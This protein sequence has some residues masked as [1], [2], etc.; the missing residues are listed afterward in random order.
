MTSM[1]VSAGAGADYLLDA[2]IASRHP[3]ERLVFTGTGS[4]YFRIWIV[5][6]LLTILTLGIYSAWAKVRRT[7]Y[8]YDCTRLAGSSF[9]YH[10][11]PMAILKGR[12]VAVLFFG[13]YN[14]AAN[15][16][17]VMGM[18][19]LA[20]LAL[21]GPW[22]VWKSLQ[23]KLYNSSYRAIRFGFRGTARKV[24]LVYLLFP[25]LTFLT[26]YVLA[27]LTHQQMK[28]FQH[29]ESRYGNT[30]FS[31]HGTAG[32]FYKAYLIGFLV[33]LAGI[34]VIG[35]TFGG[36][37]AAMASAG[38]LKQTALGTFAL[39][40]LVLYLWLFSLFPLFLTMIQNLIWNNTRLGGH[41]FKSEMRARRMTFIVFTNII[42]IVLTLGL[43][44]PFAKIRSMKYRIESMTLIPVSNLDD[45]VAAEQAEASATGEGAA[46]MLD[47]DLSL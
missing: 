23:F 44:I 17:P 12:V 20:L 6:L 38:G 45:F 14:L 25:V 34:A 33:A 24:Y 11:S 29:D 8:F 37:L 19:M 10:G 13:A 5:N 4:E 9:E 16:S 47:F 27:P 18:L 32:S 21:V 43:F 22:L 30:H 46:D 1:G 35:V 40:V 39:F 42:G 31:F 3:P 41:R 15:H 36:M 7:R 2:A 28:K 26:A